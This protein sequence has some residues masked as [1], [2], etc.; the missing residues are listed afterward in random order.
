MAD[1]FPEYE[2]FDATGL[3]AL[4]ADGE[5]T[6]VELMAAAVTRIEAS[7]INAVV[8]TRFESAAAEIDAGL[9]S[10]PFSGVPF[11]IKDLA[12]QEGE[13]VTFG[14]VL[15]R[16]YVGEVTPTAIG[17]MLGTGLVSLGRTNTPEFGLLPTTEPVLHGPTRNPW[18]RS[19]SPGGSSGGAAAAVA[20][21]I[22]PMAQASDGGGS[23]RIPASACGL[24]GMKPTR[25]R[26]PLHPPS[27]ADYVSTSLCVSRS[28]RDTAGLLD[29]IA[30]SIAGAQ[31][32]PP[33]PGE[34][35][36]VS[37]ATDPGRLRIALATESF[38]GRRLHPSCVAAVEATGRLLEDLGHH[39]EVASP[40]IS[41]EAIS[42]A[43][44]AV[45]M[46]MAETAALLVLDEVESR[47]GGRQMRRVLGDVRA[48]RLVSRLTARR[49]G[50]P[51]FEP[52]TLGLIEH[53]AHLTPG[54]LLMAMTALQEA[55]YA[56]GSFLEGYDLFVTPTLG[57]PPL[58][59]GAIDQTRPFV[60]VAAQLV[61]YVPFTPI[62]NFSGFP[63]MSMPL[64]W[65]GDGLP[66]GVH[67][68]GRQNGE[69]DLFGI[70]GQVERAQPW[71]AHRPA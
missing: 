21:G 12:S 8:S 1:P 44:L 60:D 5:V 18:D 41:G 28:V 69:A 20:A 31:Y 42:E 19:R 68:M 52:F 26:V 27:I 33:R 10:G 51:G 49:A 2:Q 24:F 11:L 7:E 17:R 58:P 53:S 71:F 59:L 34:P 15:F 56:L 25:G 36:V 54:R 48:I 9:A 38:D 3:A 57:E 63:A 40:E 37:S 30:G 62:G 50:S 14:S 22:V 43:F 67:F 47:R 70:A 35:Y 16:D 23:I 13:P 55:S 32:R 61:D 66:I 64:H 4:V 29:A 46:S 45:W 6:A 65:D 39:V